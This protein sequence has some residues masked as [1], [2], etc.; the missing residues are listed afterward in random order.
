ML[1]FRDCIIKTMNTE[2][3]CLTTSK[4]RIHFANC[5]F[6]RGQIAD[7]IR[8]LVQICV[9]RKHIQSLRT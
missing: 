6:V 2:I 3:I 5:M 9:S 4:S 1:R 8:K 7:A